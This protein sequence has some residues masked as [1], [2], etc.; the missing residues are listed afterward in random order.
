MFPSIQFSRS[1][2]LASSLCLSTLL[3]VENSYAGASNALLNCQSTQPKLSLVG[4]I[5]GDFAEFSLSLEADGKIKKMDDTTHGIQVIADFESGVFTLGVSQKEGHNLQFYAY[6]NTMKMTENTDSALSATFEGR[7]IQAPKP[8][9]EG[10]ITRDA[11]LFNVKMVCDY[12]Y[13]I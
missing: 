10:E 8:D 1:F 13:E 12:N 7:I 2:M 11:F 3:L 4:E 5:P 6:P 9:Y